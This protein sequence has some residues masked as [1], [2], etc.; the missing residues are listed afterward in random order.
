MT[1]V[2]VKVLLSW[3]LDPPPPWA[4]LSAWPGGSCLT[5][6]SALSPS[7]T[8]GSLSLR[9][10]CSWHLRPPHSCTE[11][12]WVTH[13]RV[14]VPSLWGHHLF[15]FLLEGGRWPVLTEAL[16][17]LLSFSHSVTSSSLRPRGLQQAWL[18]YWRRTPVLHYIPECSQTHV[19]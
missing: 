6:S 19:H 7:V 5:S 17:S 13:G 9:V 12:A 3:L 16:L 18:P 15:S 4:L 14:R 8:E 2:K 10:L 11:A 1:L